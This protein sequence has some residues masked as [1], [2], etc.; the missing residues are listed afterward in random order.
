MQAALGDFYAVSMADVVWCDF[1]NVTILIAGVIYGDF[2][3]EHMRNE[4]LVLE[5]SMGKDLT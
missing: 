5:I 2:A 1:Q 4:P 3:I